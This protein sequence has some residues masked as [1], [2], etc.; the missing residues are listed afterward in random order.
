MRGVFCVGACIFGYAPGA[1]SA[2]F[3]GADLAGKA[4][5][6]NRVGKNEPGNLE[7]SWNTLVGGRNRLISPQQLDPT[8]KAPIP[9]LLPDGLQPGGTRGETTA[10]GS[11]QDTSPA[12][13]QTPQTPQIPE[14]SDKTQKPQTLTHRVIQ[15]RRYGR[16]VRKADGSLV[17]IETQV[18]R[19]QRGDS[20]RAYGMGFERRHPQQQASNA[21]APQPSQSPQPRRDAAPDFVVPDFAVP[22]FDDS[23][24]SADPDVSADPNVKSDG[25]AGDS[26]QASDVLVV[27]DPGALPRTP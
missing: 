7:G 9:E 22:D 16:T 4:R 27:Q 20:Q 14:R 10:N 12:S 15:R 3:S 21:S 25:H 18:I 6:G 8:D 1:M 19:V 13:S 17:R 2:D 24:P 5:A 23:D 11:T 26:V